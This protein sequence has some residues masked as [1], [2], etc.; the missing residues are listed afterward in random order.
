M[1]GP[2][3]QVL[4][5]G[6]LIILSAA[7]YVIHYLIFRDTHHIFIYLVGDIAFVFFEVLLVTLVIH[8]LLSQREKRQRLEKLNMVIGAFFSEVGTKLLS[9]FSDLDP[10]LNKI[11]QELV[12]TGEWSEDDFLA[13]SNR[14]RSYQ[15]EVDIRQVELTGLKALLVKNRDFLLRLLENPNLLEHESFTELLR[16]VFHL[17]EELESRDDIE[18]LP[19]TDYNHLAG[20][21]K[22]V[23]SQLV[24]Q[25]LDYMKHLKDNYPYLF[26]LALRTN[27]FDQ[28][29][30]P[31]VS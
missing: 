2:H 30:S 3:W 1:K 22:R 15:Y 9:Y 31:I 16:A 8:S 19:D 14:L 12:V 27:P 18:S 25:W 7:V 4:L 26:S 20:D 28:E 11:R 21:I 17:T 24:H 6:A 23:Y 29:A 10:H 13:V 5:G